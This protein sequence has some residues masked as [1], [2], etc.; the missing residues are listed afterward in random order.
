MTAVTTK[1]SRQHK[2]RTWSAFGDLGRKP[3]EYE[4]VTHKLNHT[5]R[6]PPLELSPDAHGNV[7]LKKHR[8]GM[9][10]SCPRLG[11]VSRSRTAHLPQ[12][13]EEPGRQRDLYR[14][15][16]SRIRRVP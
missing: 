16:P 1:A 11:C 7:W 12:I 6:E 9:R 15:H 2:L 10:L 13:R 4:V 3:T 8:D 5:M 14:R